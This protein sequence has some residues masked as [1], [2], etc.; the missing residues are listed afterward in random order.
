M[1]LIAC[2]VVLIGLVVSP[3]AVAEEPVL[4]DWQFQ[5]ALN[6]PPSSEFPLTGVKRTSHAS[7]Q[8]VRF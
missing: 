3:Q 1:R 4:E 8:R 7:P 2:L 6:A 5:V